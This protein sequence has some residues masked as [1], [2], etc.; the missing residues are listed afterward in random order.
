MS[1]I[2]TVKINDREVAHITN[3]DETE[4]AE[5]LSYILRTAAISIFSDVVPSWVGTTLIMLSKLI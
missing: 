5:Q 2:S 3:D 1:R 4:V